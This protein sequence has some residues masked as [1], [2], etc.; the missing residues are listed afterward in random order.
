[1]TA[2]QIGDPVRIEV[3]FADGKVSATSHAAKA[4]AASP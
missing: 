2:L 3:T 4:A 1:M